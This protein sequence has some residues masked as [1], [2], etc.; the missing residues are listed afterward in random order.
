MGYTINPTKL[1][2]LNLREVKGPTPYEIVIPENANMAA[3]TV[4]K[5]SGLH[6]NRAGM[7]FEDAQHNVQ[8]WSFAELD[9]DA[10]RLAAGLAA[11]GIRKGERVAIHTGFR[12][13]TGLAHLAIYKL[14]AI[15]VTLSQLYGPDT[16]A[17]VLNHGEAEII[18]TQDTAW[19]RYRDDTAA[20]PTLR[21]C[22]VVGTA[23]GDELSQA[24]LLAAVG[25]SRSS[26]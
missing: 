4:A 25:N 19:D 2:S 18:I 12:P 10:T 14:G 9:R 22:I 26:P 16:L 21:H 11:L 17:H 23:E 5:Y 20:F 13:E 3:D 6:P 15:A 7:V 8:S 24:C 1:S